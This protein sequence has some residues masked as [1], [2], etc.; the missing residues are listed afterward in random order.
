MRHSILFSILAYM[1][2][3]L[4][5]S[6]WPRV[7]LQ[8]LCIQGPYE[9][10][11]FSLGKYRRPRWPL[12]ADIPNREL[13]ETVVRATF[14]IHDT[15]P[16]GDHISASSFREIISSGALPKAG[17]STDLEGFVSIFN[18]KVCLVL[19]ITNRTWKLSTAL[20]LGP[21]KL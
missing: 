10:L 11:V 14:R 15:T 6:Q 3:F 5:L 12:L 20:W 18:A 9:R 2:R 8:L 7:Y 1:R 4:Y 17:F 21:Y 19:T 13:L 16:Q